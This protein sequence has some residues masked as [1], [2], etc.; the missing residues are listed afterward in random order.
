MFPP[1]LGF[2]SQVV[3]LSF[4]FLYLCEQ[5]LR[6]WQEWWSQ[7]AGWGLASLASVHCGHL[8]NSF[9]S[10]NSEAT[11]TY[12]FPLSLGQWFDSSLLWIALIIG[13]LSLSMILL[14][15]IS[16]LSPRECFSILF[17]IWDPCL[18]CSRNWLPSRLLLRRS[19]KWQLL[20]L[21]SRK[22]NRKN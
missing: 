3:L 15:L 12:T 20:F 16:L 4:P 1:H 17:F 21:S 5:V 22:W 11:R 7:W 14:L 13:S 18:L 2:N 19:F 6:L 9:L 8:S 10:L